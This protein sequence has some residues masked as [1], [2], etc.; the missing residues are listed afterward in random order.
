MSFIHGIELK[1]D[2]SGARATA[3]T[4]YGVIGI[5]GTA[6]FADEQRFP[7][8]TPVLLNKASERK[9]LLANARAKTGVR[10]EAGTLPNALDAIYAQAGQIAPAVIVVR[11][12]E[13]KA[14]PLTPIIGNDAEFTGIHALK[15]AES[16]VGRSPKILLAPGFTADL[17]AESD[18][19]AYTQ[20]IQATQA[21]ANALVNVADRLRAFAIVDVPAASEGQ[22]HVGAIAVAKKLNFKRLELCYPKVIMADPE[23]ADKRVEVDQAAVQ[24]GALAMT[25]LERGPYKSSSNRVVNGVLGL[26]Q[27]V[28]FQQGNPGCLANS[29]NA[30]H[31]STLI[32]Y[33]GF[34]TW[35]NR[36]SEKANPA[37]VFK[38]VAIVNDLIAESIQKGYLWVID[39]PISRT[40]SNDVVTSVNHFLAALKH[41][42][43]IS[44]GMA[45]VEEND[46]PASELALGHLT[47]RYEI[48]VPSP[49]EHVTFIAKISNKG[50]EL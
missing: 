24:A 38:N 8:N 6:P 28:D 44:Y 40:L 29:L 45:T 26:T 34:R 17:P 43:W 14:S 9:A 2:A 3:M 23:D 19:E 50:N 25:H 31:I 48:T 10:A 27:P 16:R 12:A 4:D 18:K 1:Q 49:A 11:V 39:E 42:G 22:P 46:N 37:F 21:L 5:V 41:K 7:L 33:Q 13:D 47:L 30:K 36:S 15:L 20:A 35:G 32:G